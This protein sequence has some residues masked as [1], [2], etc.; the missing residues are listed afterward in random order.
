ML[1]TLAQN[2]LKVEPVEGTAQVRIRVRAVRAGS[3]AEASAKARDV[4]R[5]LVP[6]SGYRLSD[7]EPET[8]DSD[9]KQLVPA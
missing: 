3:P 6:V 9:E 4:V 1:D 5:R 2:G 8:A 7:P